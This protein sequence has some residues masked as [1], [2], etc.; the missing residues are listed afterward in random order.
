[1]PGSPVIWSR[2]RARMRRQYLPYLVAAMLSVMVPIQ[3]AQA[4][5]GTTM[6]LTIDQQ[7]ATVNGQSINLDTAPVLDAASSRTFVPVR[8]IGET[9]GAYIGWDGDAQQVTYLTGDTRIV[10]SIGRKTAQVNGRDVTLDAA[11]YIDRNGRTLVPVRFVSEQLGASVT[12]NGATNAVTVSAPWVGRVV[13]IQDR[14]FSPATL[15]VSAGTRITWVNLDN[16]QHDVFNSSF[17]SPA[18]SRGQAFS[19]TVT[20][21][22]NMPY[23]CS[24]HDEMTGTILVQP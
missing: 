7:R 21:A 19:Y 11:P 17:E 8:F 6:V 23:A 13:T 14:K 16:T 4:A 3:N 9:L 12:W 10:L 5:A 20:T 15:T 2:L 24:F 18:L 1:M 22:G